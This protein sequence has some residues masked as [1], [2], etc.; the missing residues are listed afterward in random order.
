MGQFARTRTC[1]SLAQ[2]APLRQ[3]KPVVRSRDAENLRVLD[4]P[5]I[6]ACGRG[7]R[8]GEAAVA[9]LQHPGPGRPPVPVPP[10]VEQRS[11]PVCPPCVPG[12]RPPQP[13][14][15]KIP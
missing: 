14:S 12:G 11:P 15:P 6:E 8:A 3:Q 2:S 7:G 5:Q 13:P 10:P 9:P 4:L 1:A